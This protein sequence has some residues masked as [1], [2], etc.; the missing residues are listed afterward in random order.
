MISIDFPVWTIVIDYI[1]AILMW[2]FIFNFL[3]KIIFTTSS[4]FFI[5]K[6]YF[7][8]SEKIMIFFQFLI[9]SFMPPQL[10]TIY[11]AWLIFI[12]RFYLLPLT[13]GF[14]AIGQLS[15]PFETKFYFFLK[16]LVYDIFSTL[17]T[18]SLI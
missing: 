3:L 10:N 5:I 9:P 13:K 15:F 11:L 18:S 16:R 1:F 17:F 2:L 14:Y 4:N 8:F 7:K 6:Y 12:F